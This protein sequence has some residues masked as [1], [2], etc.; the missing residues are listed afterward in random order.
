MNI[1]TLNYY[2]ALYEEKN[3]TKAAERLYISRQALSKTINVL[4]K[5][6]GTTLVHGKHNG[7]EFT[8]AGEYFYKRATILLH[9]Y[10]KTI[11]E[12]QLMNENGDLSI[13]LGVDYMTTHIY[14]DDA[15]QP[16]LD[17]HQTMHIERI[18]DT[19]DNLEKGYLENK[20]DVILSHIT[21]P[22]STTKTW[23]SHVPFGVLMKADDSYA[24]KKFITVHDLEKR[25]VYATGGNLLFVKE[26]N[27][28]FHMIHS[29]CSVSAT[30]T[31]ELFTN[32]RFIEEKNI[33]FLTTGYY[34]N[35]IKGS[36]QFKFVPFYYDG[37]KTLP[38]HDVYLYGEKIFVSRSEIHEL[39]LFLRSLPTKVPAK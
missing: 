17:I 38:N 34:I 23:V 13:R 20:Y 15:L 2:I 12:I 7:V 22:S 4:E 28:F 10:E 39:I 16:F 14:D 31:N 6:L 11:S 5:E 24:K 32:L 9:D 19:P 1:N 27:Q 26:C 8:Q 37:L 29:T 30:A 3:I 25:N 35:M 36:K 21:V 18:I 33:L